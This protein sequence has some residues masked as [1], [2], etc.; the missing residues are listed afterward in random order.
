[1]RAPHGIQGA[2]GMKAVVYEK[3]GGCEYLKLADIPKPIPEPNE[4]L[5]EIG[6]TSVNPIDWKIREGY[7]RT[8]IPYEF[9]ITP[10]VDAAGTV[11][12]VGSDVR[13]FRVGDKVYAYCR[14][15][16]VHDGTYTE[17]VAV[18]EDA[19]ARIPKNLSFAEAAAVPL[20]GLAAWQSLF[21]TARPK[22]GDRMLI[23]GG[24]GGIGSMAIQF[25]K[26]AGAKV[27]TT[28]RKA[29]HDYVKRLGADV[30]IDYTAEDVAERIKQEESAGM[31]VVCDTIGGDTLAAS[32]AVVVPGG[33]L[34]SVAERPDPVVAS[35]LS[36]NVYFVSVRPSGVEL[37]EITALF[38]SRTVKLPHIEQ[39]PLE[40]AAIAQ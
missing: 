31:D 18:D 37:R 29:N 22:A 24:A 30:P 6:Y 23:Q 4:V 15:P 7:L 5:I 16:K 13:G 10:G 19:V 8:Q 2:S 32:Y 9:P 40:K 38:E 27:Y 25:A 20:A 26:R 3:F 36:I 35:R 28:A 21:D 14:K 33:T 12:E 11:V 17:F 34:V 1:M 39:M